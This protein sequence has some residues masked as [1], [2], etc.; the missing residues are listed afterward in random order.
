MAYGKEHSQP[1]YFTH[2]FVFVKSSGG[3]RLTATSGGVTGTVFEGQTFGASK[4]SQIYVLITEAGNIIYQF[5]YVRY[6]YA[7]F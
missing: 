5:I 2:R 4:D 1:T 3:D 6:N 7:I